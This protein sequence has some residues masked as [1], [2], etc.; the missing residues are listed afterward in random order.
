MTHITEY[1]AFAV[2]ASTGVEHLSSHYLKKIQE[3]EEQI[4]SKRF[5]ETEARLM[6][7]AFE[8]RSWCQRSSLTWTGT[9]GLEDYIIYITTY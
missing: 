4:K 1:P 2:S 6:N 9:I 7:Q 5:S 3:A 8:V